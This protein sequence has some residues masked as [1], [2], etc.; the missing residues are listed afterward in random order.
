V[1][2]SSLTNEHPD[3]QNSVCHSSLKD[4]NE[5]SYGK[6]GESRDLVHSVLQLRA[7]SQ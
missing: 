4:Y 1:K 6:M 7:D 5:H 3:G 2:R